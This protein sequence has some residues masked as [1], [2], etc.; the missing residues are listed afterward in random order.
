MKILCCNDQRIGVRKGD[1]AVDIPP[2]SVRAREP[3]GHKG[4]TPRPAG[5]Y[6]GPAAG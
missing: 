6:T 5:T 2:V 4:T 1:T 3:K